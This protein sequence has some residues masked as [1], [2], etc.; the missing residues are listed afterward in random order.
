MNEMWQ[1]QSIAHIRTTCTQVERDERERIV[2]DIR[3]YHKYDMILYAS[4]EHASR[5]DIIEI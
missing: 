3:L 4:F 1:A 5:A 2:G